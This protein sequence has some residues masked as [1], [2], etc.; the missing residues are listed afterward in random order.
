MK[1]L[2]RPQ[3]LLRYASDGPENRHEP[4]ERSR[5]SPSEQVQVRSH[6]S[7]K[8]WQKEDDPEEDEEPETLQLCVLPRQSLGQK[9]HDDPTAVQRRDGKHV[10]DRED[11]VQQDRLVEG[12]DKPGSRGLWQQPRKT[13]ESG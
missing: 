4:L 12:L 5:N 3:P 1:Q 10:E 7:S 8:H 2:L 11:Q 6:L 13:N 9:A